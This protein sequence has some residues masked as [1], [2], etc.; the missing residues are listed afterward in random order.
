[1]RLA[2]V[3]H[4]KCPDAVG[5]LAP[6]VHSHKWPVLEALLILIVG[7]RCKQSAA[8]S[9]RRDQ[10]NLQIASTRRRQANF[11]LNVLEVADCRTFGVQLELDRALRRDELVHKRECY[12][13]I[14]LLG[15]GCPLAG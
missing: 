2:L 1:M 4:F 8:S 9:L 12:L 6:I 13:A 15:Y 10:I 3:M 11:R 5:R 14:V 7:S